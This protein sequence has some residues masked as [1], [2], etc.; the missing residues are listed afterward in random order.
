MARPV[1]RIGVLGGA[2]DPPHLAH[3][4][5]AQAACEQLQLDQL[6]IV[7]T[8]QAWHKSRG[9][10]LATHRLA[11]SQLAFSSLPQGLVDAC[12]TRRSGPSYTI[13]TLHD[14]QVAEPDAQLF[15]IIG[16]DQAQAL[17]TWKD[18]QEIL[19]SA[20]ICVADR[21]CVTAAIGALDTETMIPDRFRHLKMPAM[22]ISATDI[23]GR[24][25]AQQD[26]TALVCE[27]V[28][29]YIADQHLYQTV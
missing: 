9:L 15:L 5:L 8:G 10:T 2:F 21:A 3:L 12:E 4:A 24:I 11:M 7:P 27:P 14:L 19:K 22:S 26:V 28:A 29:R 1:R 13:D 6:R 16:T 20:T 18:W 23:R 25:A 17:P